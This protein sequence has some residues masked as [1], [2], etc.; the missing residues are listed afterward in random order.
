MV[1]W[2]RWIS[3]ISSQPYKRCILWAKV[4]GQWYVRFRFSIIV[5]IY[6]DA[7]AFATSSL[8]KRDAIAFCD[9]PICHWAL[10][11]YI[12]IVVYFIF[13]ICIIINCIM[14]KCMLRTAFQWLI[15]RITI[16][17]TYWKFQFLCAQFIRVYWI[18][19]ISIIKI[20]ISNAYIHNDCVYN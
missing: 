9:D 10:I 4:F 6:Y 19:Q 14:I 18:T 13:N 11:L 16:V 17:Y 7:N 20:Y 3:N 15:R 5:T 8:L 2:N 12:Y 1:H